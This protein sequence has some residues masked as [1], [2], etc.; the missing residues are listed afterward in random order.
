M[1]HVWVGPPKEGSALECGDELLAEFDCDERSPP[2]LPQ[3]VAEREEDGVRGA[4]GSENEDGGGSALECGD[5]LLADVDCDEN[6]QA[7]EFDLCL[8]GRTLPD[9]ERVPKSSSCLLSA[10]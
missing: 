3:P 9:S 4:T 10:A 2:P 8:L 5:E 6:E 7:D 1:S